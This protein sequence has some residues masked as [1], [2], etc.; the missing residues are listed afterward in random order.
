MTPIISPRVTD[1]RIN[2]T[3]YDLLE[4]VNPLTAEDIDQAIDAG[5]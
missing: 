1:R 5:R 2:L 4:V 3:P